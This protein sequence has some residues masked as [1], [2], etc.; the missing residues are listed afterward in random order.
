[1]RMQVRSM[2]SVHWGSRVALSCGVGHRHGLDLTL[3]WLWYR[4]AAVVPIQPL[5]WEL[6]Y[7][8][9]ISPP[10]KKNPQKKDHNVINREPL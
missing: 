8:T 3:L 1:M 2:A 9:S 7:A 4:L 5:A 6:P 10:P